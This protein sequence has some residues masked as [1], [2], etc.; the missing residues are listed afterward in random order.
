M[1]SILPY[2][3]VE[4]NLVEISSRSIIGLLVNHGN[5]DLYRI[6]S[7]AQREGI[8]FKLVFI[9][10][11][12]ELQPSKLFDPE[13]M[14]KLFDLGYNMALSGDPWQNYPPGYKE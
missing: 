11:N 8:N 10:S 14:K 4:S 5:G 2:E 13:V 3:P 12:F 6:Y 7:L 1:Q 9:P